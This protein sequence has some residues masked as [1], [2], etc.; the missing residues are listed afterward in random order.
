M[1]AAIALGGL[2][3]ITRIPA[4]PEDDIFLCG[5]GHMFSMW[6]FIRFTRSDLIE[7]LTNFKSSTGHELKS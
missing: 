3:L 4:A 1:M 5:T 2:M 6:I 7:R